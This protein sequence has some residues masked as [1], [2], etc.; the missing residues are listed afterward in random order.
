MLF[1]AENPP[2]V[3]DSIR[4]AQSCHELASIADRITSIESS[5][6]SLSTTKTETLTS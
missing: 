1:P 4:E 3:G 5:F 2:L 6:E